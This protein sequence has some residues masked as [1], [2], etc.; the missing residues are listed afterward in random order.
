VRRA[1]PSFS[2]PQ[3]SIARVRFTETQVPLPEYIEQ[4]KA[5]APAKSGALDSKLEKY[6]AGSLRAPQVCGLCDR[7]E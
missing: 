4:L 6:Q 7:T 2:S 3:P 1:S 5:L